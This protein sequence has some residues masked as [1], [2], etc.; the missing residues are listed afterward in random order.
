VGPP[1][2]EDAVRVEQEVLAPLA[3]GPEGGDHV[4]LHREPPTPPPDDLDEGLLAG[5]FA[6]LGVHDGPVAEV[7]DP[8]QDAVLHPDAT[9]EAVP[10]IDLDDVAQAEARH[11]ALE[12]TRL[13]GRVT[14]GGHGAADSSD[15]RSVSEL[16][17][18]SKTGGAL[19][20]FAAKARR[21]PS[22]VRRC[23]PR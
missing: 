20:L 15:M 11:L 9:G 4:V 7:D 22:D 2:V 5:P 13:A 19:R 23:T 1:L 12:A 3:D 18:T 6:L 8:S 10:G 16:S 14:R 21:D 17:V